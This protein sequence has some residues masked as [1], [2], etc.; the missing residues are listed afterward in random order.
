MKLWRRAVVEGSRKVGQKENVITITA[1]EED[2]K[3]ILFLCEMIRIRPPLPS[4]CM[5]CVYVYH[6]DKVF[7]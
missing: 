2:Y 3:L 1:K 7:G 4:F 5:S 6:M